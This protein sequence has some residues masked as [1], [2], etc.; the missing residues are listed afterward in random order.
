MKTT[1]AIKN[2]ITNM[3]N[4][5]VFSSID[6]LSWGHRTAIDQA[7]SRMRAQGAIVRVAR[8]LYAVKGQV[9]DARMVASSLANK[10][11]EQVGFIASDK[12][13]SMLTLAT[14]GASRTLKTQGQTVKFRKMSLRKIQLSSSPLGNALLELWMIGEKNLTKV[15]IRQALTDVQEKDIEPFAMLLPSW[16]RMAVQETLAPRKSIKIGLS[17]AYDWSNANMRDD[18]LISKV[19]EKHKFEDLARL[20]MYYGMIKVKR[21]FKDRAFDPLTMISV[22][23]MLT[24]IGKGLNHLREHTH[25]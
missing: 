20:C 17:G 3:P 9:V 7:L 1:Q 14:S 15:D 21:V 5:A 8:G 2:A 19:L 10:T 18:V 4:G 11:G 22:K 16:L 6:F 23:R 13:E 12:V 24:N 25:A